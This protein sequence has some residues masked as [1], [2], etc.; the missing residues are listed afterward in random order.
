MPDRPAG[1][2]DGEGRLMN[3]PGRHEF[4]CELLR[5]VKVR[6]GEVGRVAGRVLVPPVP[7]IPG[8]DGSEGRVLQIAGPQP[9][10]GGGEALASTPVPLNERGAI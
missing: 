10:E 7:A 8:S 3:P 6:G 9:V 1:S 2:L 5:P 4:R